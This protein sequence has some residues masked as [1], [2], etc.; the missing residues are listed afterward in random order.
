MTIDEEEGTWP[1]VP[2]TKDDDRHLKVDLAG[3]DISAR[4]VAR[5]LNDLDW[6]V[7][8][9]LEE[10]DLVKIDV[11]SRRHLPANYKT[12]IVEI[13]RRLL[14]PLGQM[15]E[16][17][18]D[19]STDQSPIVYITTPADAEGRRVLAEQARKLGFDWVVFTN[20]VEG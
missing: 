8:T 5:A 16:I 3:L 2:I 7:A 6:A 14:G 18:V 12:Q 10:L 9:A 4:A 1:K 17:V 15:H 11:K 20:A 13:V 19:N